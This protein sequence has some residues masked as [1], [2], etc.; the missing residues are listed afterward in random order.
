MLPICGLEVFL[1]LT[2]T[3]A[4]MSWSAGAVVA[5]TAFGFVRGYL[6]RLVL[7]PTSAVLAMPTR[8]IEIPWE[9]VTRIGVYLP[10]GGL[11][12]TKYFFV[13]IHNR[14]PAG[15]WEIDEDT[16]QVQDR[17]GLL[18]AVREYRSMCEQTSDAR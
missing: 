2:P 12:A 15:K 3:P 11:G 10:G 5:L 14:E 13:S 9:R 1:I 6:R 17:P 4:W 8:R 18:E 16:I 7:S